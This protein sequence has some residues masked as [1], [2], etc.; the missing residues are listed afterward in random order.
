[1]KKVK[2]NA[3][4]GRVGH[5]DNAIEMDKL[6]GFPGIKVDNIKVVCSVPKWVTLVPMLDPLSRPYLGKRLLQ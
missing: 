2:K 1:M 3:I 4:V 5:F 6:E